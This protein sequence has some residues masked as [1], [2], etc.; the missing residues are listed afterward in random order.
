M[1]SKI[2]PH[3]INSHDAN[4]IRSGLYYFLLVHPDVIGMRD[5]LVS[6]LALLDLRSAMLTHSFAVESL[7][8]DHFFCPDYWSVASKISPHKINS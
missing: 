2:S 4:E 1:A 7:Y 3:K 6:C 5:F 8:P